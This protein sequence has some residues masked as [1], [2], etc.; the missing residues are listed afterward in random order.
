MLLTFVTPWKLFQSVGNL[1]SVFV[2]STKNSVSSHHI[3]PIWA[4]ALFSLLIKIQNNLNKITTLTFSS[5][6]IIIAKLDSPETKGNFIFC[7]SHTSFYTWK[8]TLSFS[9]RLLLPTTVTDWDS[10][11]SPQPRVSMT[12]VKL[13]G[14]GA[15]RRAPEKESSQTQHFDRAFFMPACMLPHW[16]MCKGQRLINFNLAYILSRF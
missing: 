1:F 7:G 3:P 16:M 8:T 13:G 9:T 6:T 11:K 15:K 14:L 5:N 2:Y 12:R 4:F 10:H